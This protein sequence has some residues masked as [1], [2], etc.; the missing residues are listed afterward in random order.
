MYV[1]QRNE[2]WDI[3]HKLSWLSYCKNKM[4]SHTASLRAEILH[5]L[6]VAEVYMQVNT[7]TSHA[8]KPNKLGEREAA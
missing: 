7:A 6:E 5:F 3:Y 1:S 4:F 2:G 8:K